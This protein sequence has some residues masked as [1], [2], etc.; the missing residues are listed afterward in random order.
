MKQRVKDDLKQYLLRERQIDEILPSCPDVEE[1]WK[2]IAT[3]YLPDGIREFQAYPVSSLG[4]M[5]YIG[6]AVASYWDSDWEIY[7]KIE[8]LY[9]YM[10]NKRGYDYLDEYIREEVLTLSETESQ[11]L[12]KLIGE[13]ASRTNNL[14]CHAHIEPG[15]QQAFQAYTDSLEQLYLFGCAIQLH[16]MGYKMVKCE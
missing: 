6:M 14:L 10:R 12:E 8:D 3:S 15:T 9:V 2:K 5:M 4:W 16:K 11:K 7:S 13:C 1:L